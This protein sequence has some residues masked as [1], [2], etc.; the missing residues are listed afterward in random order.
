MF[1]GCKNLNSV[2]MLATDVSKTNCLR[3]WLYDAGKDATSRKLK[4]NSKT[5]YEAIK[6]NNYLPTN[7]QAGTSGTTIL[8][9]DDH[10]ITSTISSTNP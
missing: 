4:V 1:K 6:N 3:D 8:D 9:K 7:W 5:E 2:T 10:D